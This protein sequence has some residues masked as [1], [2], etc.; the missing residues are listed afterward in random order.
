MHEEV[1][2]AQRA[3]LA[4]IR[5]GIDA[6]LGY[7]SDLVLVEQVVAG[8]RTPPSRGKLPYA[9]LLEALLRY[10]GGG[11]G[12]ETYGRSPIAPQSF[13]GPCPQ[14]GGEYPATWL[15][16]RAILHLSRAGQPPQQLARLCIAVEQHQ[17]VALEVVCD[18]AQPWQRQG[19]DASLRSE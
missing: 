4:L 5:R 3:L 16:A 13:P 11:I 1:E 9:A 10:S 12:Y 19:P 14:R 17:I 2:L 15:W 7:C 6:H 8:R 18:E